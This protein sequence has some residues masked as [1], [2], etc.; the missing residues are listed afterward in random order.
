MRHI[1]HWHRGTLVFLTLAVS[2]AVAAPAAEAGHGRGKQRY[3]GY[4]GRDRGPDRVIIHRSSSS[5]GA[6]IGGF[7]GGLIVGTAI[8]R[9]QPYYETR[10]EGGPR[11]SYG[12]P[13]CHERFS[14]LDR[15]GDHA[16][17]HRHP[18]VAQVIVISTGEYIDDC[19]WQDGRWVG[20]Y[21]NTGYDRGGYRDDRYQ[22][23]R[24]RD[25]RYRDDR[26]RDNS[27]G[28]DG[29]QGNRNDED[30]QD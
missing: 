27:C 28:D 19:S 20:G 30:W 23:R 4:R 25:D 22:D 13:Y 17:R 29:S 15:Y 9:P 26:Y 24:Y 11:Y 21:Q 2:L 12:D 5:T 3:K 14:S 6:A 10:Y 16:R 7:I 1:S 18:R 8:A